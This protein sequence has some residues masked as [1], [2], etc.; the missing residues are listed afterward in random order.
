MLWFVVVFCGLMLESMLEVFCVKG[1]VYYGLFDKVLVVC[2]VLFEVVGCVV[3]LMI[4]GIFIGIGEI[5]E[6][7]IELLLVLCDVYLVYGYL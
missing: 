2:L 1:G 5:V 4:L 6:E 7:C 3:M